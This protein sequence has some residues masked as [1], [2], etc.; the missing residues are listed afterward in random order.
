MMDKNIHVIL[1]AISAGS[2]VWIHSV[3]QIN[4]VSE[5]FFLNT[6]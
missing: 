1:Q 6:D 3:N 2:V 5:Y 4:D